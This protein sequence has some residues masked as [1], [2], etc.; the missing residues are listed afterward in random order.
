M[1]DM[2]GVDKF[3]IAIAGETGSGRPTSSTYATELQRQISGLRTCVINLVEETPQGIEPTPSVDPAIAAVLTLWVHEGEVSASG[4]AQ[5]LP[6][7]ATVYKIDEQPQWG[8]ERDWPLGTRSP[9]VKRL[10]FVLRNPVFSLEGFAKY[11][12][13][14]HAPKARAHCPVVWSYSQNVVLDMAG[15]TTPPADGIVETSFRTAEDYRDRR[16]DTEEGAAILA[17]DSATFLDRSNTV[18]LWVGEYLAERRP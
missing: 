13:E 18:S 12:S 4:L 9:G 1:D 3:M 14:V 16:Y 7:P 8:Y 5:A 11:W 6:W 10:S 2:A 17:A 15:G